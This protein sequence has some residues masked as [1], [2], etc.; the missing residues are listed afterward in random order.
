MMPIRLVID[1][2]SE[3]KTTKDA[4]HKKQME[5]KQIPR[6]SAAVSYNKPRRLVDVLDVGR[7]TD[8]LISSYASVVLF[9]ELKIWKFPH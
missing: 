9:N 3:N 7:L 2:R 8:V 1:N 4:L 6:I 5:Y